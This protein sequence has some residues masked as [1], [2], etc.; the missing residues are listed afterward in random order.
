[1]WRYFSHP[2]LWGYKS[3]V[4]LQWLLCVSH[5][6]LSLYLPR[7]VFCLSW[8]DN[9]CFAWWASPGLLI[10][11]YSLQPY[12]RFMLPV[13][14][15]DRG[16]KS[17]RVTERSSLPA[18]QTLQGHSTLPACNYLCWQAPLLL[19]HSL[20]LAKIGWLLDVKTG[21]FT[22]ENGKCTVGTL[23][24]GNADFAHK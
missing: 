7:R 2:A 18:C 5:S 6:L 14:S 3:F 12:D 21:D 20:P 15:L 11:L 24:R 4:P 16:V 9:T 22:A 13:C 23:W 1:M 17:R 8:S 19:C 10:H